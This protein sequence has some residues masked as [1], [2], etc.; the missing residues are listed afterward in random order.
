MSETTVRSPVGS[1]AQR[2][3]SAHLLERPFRKKREEAVA[4]VLSICRICNL[5]NESSMMRKCKADE[6]R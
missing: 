2:A 4:F 3:L 1:N 6:Q 5:R